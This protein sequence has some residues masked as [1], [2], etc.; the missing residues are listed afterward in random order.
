MMECGCWNGVCM[1][2]HGAM[3]LIVGLVV[4]VWA[5][6]WPMVDWR[7]VLGGLLVLGGIMKLVK[8]MCGHCSMSEKKKK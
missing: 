3:K 7:L 2:C 6:K 1:K 8:P 4:L 5:V